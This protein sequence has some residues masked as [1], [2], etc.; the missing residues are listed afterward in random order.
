MLT[1]LLGYIKRNAKNWNEYQ[2]R[3]CLNE[4]NQ[5]QKYL[6]EKLRKVS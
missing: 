3:K 2:T 5:I 4:V 6:Q 1:D